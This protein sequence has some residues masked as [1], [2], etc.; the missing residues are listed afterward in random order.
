MRVNSAM[1]AL[2]GDAAFRVP[3]PAVAAIDRY[4]LEDGWT[5]AGNG[6]LVL[7]A[8]WPADHSVIPVERLGGE[9]YEV[10]DLD[11]SLTVLDRSRAD[12][13]ARAAARCLHVARLLPAAAARCLPAADQ[14][15]CM[16]S[17]FVDG[18]HGDIQGGTR[19][20]NYPTW[21]EDLES[22]RTQACAV[23][24]GSAGAR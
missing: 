3:E 23:L 12:F 24:T 4:V 1:R 17:V 6:A 5:V 9:E 8:M 10:N 16:V 13:P 7:S 20:G 11:L 19:R 2:L 18:E 21:P 14:L 22:F 15:V